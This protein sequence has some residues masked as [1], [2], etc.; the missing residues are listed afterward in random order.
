MPRTKA[1]HSPFYVS[2]VVSW[3]LMEVVC[4]A[5]YAAILVGNE[6]ALALLKPTGAGSEAL[7]NF[8]T[9]PVSLVQ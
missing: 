3:A 2:I 5:F 7:V 4:Y 1:Q 9:L 8:A 6:S